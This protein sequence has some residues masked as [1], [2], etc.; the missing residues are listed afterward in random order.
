M[1]YLIGDRRRFLRRDILKRRSSN[2]A[3]IQV[4]LIF[5][6]KAN[7]NLTFFRHVRSALYFL[8]DI[9]N[10]KRKRYDDPVVGFARYIDL[11]TREKERER[12]RGAVS[13][14][15]LGREYQGLQNGKYRLST[16]MISTFPSK[17]P[18]VF[19]VYPRIWMK[20]PRLSNSM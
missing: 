12:E 13:V 2:W 19:R 7:K 11:P 18:F 3:L 16:K 9:P 5:Y 10:Q 1:Y 14:N 15:T 17:F 6:R 8:Q 20:S 4:L